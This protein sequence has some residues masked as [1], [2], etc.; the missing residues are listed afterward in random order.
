MELR[1]SCPNCVVPMTLENYSVN[2]LLN[3]IIGE[4]KR[5]SVLSY[6]NASG[7]MEDD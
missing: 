7:R 6:C 4:L 3:N 1:P 5:E 2:R